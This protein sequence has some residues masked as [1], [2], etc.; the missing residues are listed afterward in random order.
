MTDV[1]EDYPKLRYGLEGFPVVHEGRRMVLVRD[2]LGFCDE[3][4]LFAPPMAELLMHMNGENSLRDLQTQYMRITGTLL[5]LEHLQSVVREL[6]R[7]LFLENEG[8]IRASAE[9]V[10]R[11]Q[12]DPVRRMQHAGRS[13]QLDPE[14]LRAQ[15]NAYFDPKNGGPGLPQPGVSDRPVVGAVAPHI[16]L[17]AGGVCFS[18]AHK[19]AC[20][21]VLPETWVIL[22]TGHEPIENSMALTIKDFET[23]LGIV[24]CDREYCRELAARVSR[25]IT[26]GEYAHH[27]EHS[28]EFQAVFLAHT[29]PHARIVPIL[30]SFSLEDWEEE[31]V[32]IDEAA[33]AMRDLA[34]ENER[35]VGFM[36]SV[37]FAHVGP[38]YGDRSVP[39]AGDVR[40]NLSEDRA[41]LEILERC[42]AGEFL[43]RIRR[44]GN[45]RRVC[46]LAPL[47]VLARVLEG[48]SEGKTLQ[49]GHAVVDSH[50][51]F[52]TFAAMIFYGKG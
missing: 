15:L 36:A 27:R 16:D 45:R 39:R 47:Y 2:R 17:Q 42:D 46:G 44:D 37:D 13:Y 7:R 38:R 52:V 41:L 10:A 19:A 8:F 30:C 49:Q 48:W 22:G 20:E 4:L 50:N 6:D 33:R 51:S 1:K 3:P 14:A 32:H 23:P 28:V 29:Q 18:H 9:R 43:N 31:K 21:G 35:R 34:R 40:E 11:F 26:A 25:D 24:A 5:F 12:Q